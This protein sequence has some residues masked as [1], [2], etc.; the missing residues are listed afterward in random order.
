ML[1]R[2]A[3][4]AAAVLGDHLYVLGG[5]DGVLTLN[6][7]AGQHLLDRLP[8]SSRFANCG[9]DAINVGNSTFK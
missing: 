6:S 4:A 5:N 2:R 7:G 9:F 1:T 3:R 8:T